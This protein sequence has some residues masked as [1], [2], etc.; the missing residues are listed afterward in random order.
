[1]VLR[2]GS[3]ARHSNAALIDLLRQALIAADLPP[4]AVQAPQSQERAGVDALVSQVKGGLDLVI[5]RGGTALI[6]AVNR[7]ARVPVI[8]H[9]Q[10]VCH[11]FVHADAD[12][13]LALPVIVNAKRNARAYVT[14]SRRFWW[15]KRPRAKRC[16]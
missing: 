10:G 6:D 2:G 5:P 16:P 13:A 12:L 11:L 9:Y 4:D 8:Q 14:P 7:A 1:M 15:T 3:E